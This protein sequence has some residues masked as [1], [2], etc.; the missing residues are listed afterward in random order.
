MCTA[1]LITVAKVWKQP[2]C[3][4]TDEWIKKMWYIYNVILFSHEKEGNPAICD[5]LDGSW[6]HYAKWDKSD[7]ERQTL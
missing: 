6:G 3:L 5:S 1:A 4:S 7:R 2:K